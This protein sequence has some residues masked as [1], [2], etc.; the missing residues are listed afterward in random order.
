MPTSRTG[1][2]IMADFVKN[3][4]DDEKKILKSYLKEK[5]GG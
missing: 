5:S 2:E 3:L 1:R 4:S